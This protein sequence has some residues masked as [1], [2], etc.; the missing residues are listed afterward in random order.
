MIIGKWRS[1]EVKNKNKDEFFRASQE[2]ID[3]MGTNNSDATNMELYGV[4]NMDSL[5]H[6]L[7]VQFDSAYTAQLNMDTQ[8]TFTFK[9]D[10]TLILGY[11]GRNESGKWEIDDS[12]NLIIKELND[13]GETDKMKVMISSLDEKKLVLSFLR[14]TG[15]GGFDTS[16]VIFSRQQ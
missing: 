1:V 6:E 9:D 7:Q 8:S 15:S 4:T 14:E 10:H 12:N 11:L 13:M 16:V 3:T 2:F 5:R